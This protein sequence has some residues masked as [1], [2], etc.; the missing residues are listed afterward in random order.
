MLDD[1]VDGVVRVEWGGQGSDDLLGEVGL[2]VHPAVDGVEL[3][4][5]G[6]GK[7]HGG[8]RGAEPH[9]RGN[10]VDGQQQALLQR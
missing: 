6:K 3:N 2:G 4:P 8:V 1:L 5:L 7:V 10:E 9:M